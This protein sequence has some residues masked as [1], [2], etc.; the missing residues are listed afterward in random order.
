MVKEINKLKEYLLES[1]KI[2]KKEYK[3]ISYLIDEF[4]IKGDLN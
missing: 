4:L 3:K 2:T 1:D